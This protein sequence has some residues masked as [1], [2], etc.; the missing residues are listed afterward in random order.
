MNKSI[1]LVIL[2]CLLLFGPL[3][4]QEF[5]KYGIQDS[6]PPTGIEVGQVAPDFKAIS[7]KG[8]AVQ[9]STKLKEGPVV[10][11]FY[12]GAW[13]P[14]CV[15]YLLNISDSLDQIENKGANVFA[16]TPQ[17][18]DGIQ[19]VSDKTEGRIA[20]LHDQKG[21]IMDAYNGSFEVTEKYQKRV[22]SKK[23]NLA[24]SNGQT[25]AKLP[26]PATYVINSDGVIVYRQ[27][28]YDYK[29]RAT[30]KDILNALD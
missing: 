24:E 10:L 8:G 29:K 12:R 4:A 20:I 23:L 30:V 25:V 18:I 28:D 19:R 14:Y 11:I 1:W 7:Q 22:N 2:M 15:K 5:E 16:V 26:V 27:F 17:L 3:S 13:C 6:I 21:V 9:L